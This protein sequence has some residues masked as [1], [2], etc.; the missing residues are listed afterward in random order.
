M[1]GYAVRIALPYNKLPTT[2]GNWEELCDQIIVYEHPAP[3]ASRQHCHLLIINPKVT[4]K[5]LKNRSGIPNGGNAL[6]SFK[7]L[8]PK[9]RDSASKYIC[10]MSKGQ[11]DPKFTHGSVIHFT[12]EDLDNIKALWIT[13]N[14]KQASKLSASHKQYLEWLEEWGNDPRYITFTQSLLDPEYSASDVVKD[15]IKRDIV[16][17][18][19]GRNHGFYNQNVANQ[20]INFMRSY[21]FEIKY[22]GKI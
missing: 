21:L 2:L 14:P 19:V 5:T 7:D 1:E 13:F 15:I 20:S 11:Y 6:W 4:S 12:G 10:Y 16:K 3:P 17:W 8:K 9:T 22:P 18:L